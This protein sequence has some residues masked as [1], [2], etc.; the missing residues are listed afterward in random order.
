MQ[1]TLAACMAFTVIAA[2]VK[3]KPCSTDTQERG[4]YLRIQLVRQGL[5]VD[6]GG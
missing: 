6:G 3:L 2:S 4:A 5:K 1:D